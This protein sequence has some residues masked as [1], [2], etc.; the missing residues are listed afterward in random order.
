MQKTL[1]TLALILAVCIGIGSF[2]GSSPQRF[3]SENELRILRNH[4]RNLPVGRNDLFPGS[5]VCSG[6]HGHDPAGEALVT[7]AGIDVNIADD[8]AATMMANSARDP[9]WRAKVSHEILVNPAHQAEIEHTCTKC[10]APQ[11][12]FNAVH[13]GALHYSIADMIGDSVALDGVSCGACHMLKDT[14]I[15]KVFSGQL[16]YDTTN[17]IYGPYPEPFA[18]P[19]QS[20]VGYNVEEGAHISN[21]G[22]CAGCHTLITQTIDLSGNLTGNFFVE[23]ATYHEWLNSSFNTETH[24]NGITCQGCHIPQI[25]EKIILAANYS[26][27]AGRKPF[28]LHHLTGANVFMLRLMK[29]NLTELG[30]TATPT[31]FD[32]VITRTRRMLRTQTLDMFLTE[33]ERTTDTA[34]FELE[35]INKAGHRFPSGYPSRR[36]FVRFVVMDEQGDTLFHSGTM[37]AQ[38]DLIHQDPNYEPHHNIIRSLQQ[39]Q[40]YEMVMGDIA[41][42]VT[43]VLERAFVPLKD[44]R[45]APKGFTTTHNAYDTCRIYGQALSDPDFNRN[46]STEGTGADIVHFHVPLQGYSGELNITAEVF[47]EAV[48][49][50]WLDEMFSFS[51]TEIDLF[52]GMFN[53]AD[54]TPE[55][56]ARISR[57]SLFVS[58]KEKEKAALRIYPNPTH[59]G[60]IRLQLPQDLQVE[61]IDVFDLAGKKV[62][63]LEGRQFNGT[64]QLPARSG[65]YIIRV[66]TPAG[67]LS[68][69]TLY[70]P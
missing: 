8:W 42:N 5:G 60:R 70:L 47:Y 3:H 66:I 25:D 19:M 43:T 22:L 68:G 2:A 30:L 29:D 50:R 38:Y 65:T 16:L 26:F 6:C 58:V 41:G 53:S 24:S 31:Q 52:R 56:V 27:L 57:G 49:R 64:L 18:G 20:F 33:T 21:A 11:G 54:H 44:N 9:L 39:V 13:N 69:R 23:Q 17:T 46:G 12:H 37:N 10:H 62:M 63:S 36:A 45:L 1:F 51:S 34:F 55:L 48:P 59:D 32:S 28:G 61:Q 7:S 67:I 15:G 35:L 14:L 40:I 4:I